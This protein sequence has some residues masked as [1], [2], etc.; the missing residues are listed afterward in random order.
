TVKDRLKV[1]REKESCNEC[2]RKIDYLGM[3]LENFDPIGQWRTHYDKRKKVA[4]E[5]S[6][7]TPNGEIIQSVKQL[8]QF[9]MK[10]KSTFAKGLTTK[11]MAYGVGRKISYIEKNEIDEI[12]RKLDQKDGFKDLLTTIV[13]SQIFL[14]K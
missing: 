10:R 1:H 8:K 3:T 9:L 13:N 4:I 12:V 2:H 6:D 11:L 14:N 7:L 5:A